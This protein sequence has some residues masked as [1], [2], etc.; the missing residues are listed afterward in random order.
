MKT[1]LFFII[2]SLLAAGHLQAQ[3]KCNTFSYSQ[4][5]QQQNP[6]LK[7]KLQSIEQFTQQYISQERTA[8]RGGANVITIPVV[9]H[10]LYH[11]PEENISEAIIMEQ[12]K[13]INDCFRRQNAD[14]TN[15]PARFKAVAAD[16]E[17]E[18]K[19]AISDP[20]R[21]STSG[22]VRKYTPIRS[23]V[24]DDKMKFSASMGADAWD[25]KSY[26]NIWVCN[27]ERMAG[28]ASLPG[29]DPAK[30]GVVLSFYAFGANYYG[31]GY[32]RGKT[33][34]HEIGHWLNLKHTWGDDMCG[35]DGVSDTPKQAFYSSGCPSGTP[36][37]CGNNPNGDMYMNYMDFTDDA[38]TNLFTIGQANRMRALF[39]PN[40]AR[41]SLLVSTGLQLPLI[42]ESP[43][44]D[45]SP[46]WLYAN[47][48]PN[49]TTSNLTIDLSYD[50]RWLS[51]TLIITNLNGQI[52]KQVKVASKI[53]PL[54]ISDLQPG[55]Y[56]IY[57][58][59][60]DGETLKQKFVKL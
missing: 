26:L 38:C 41:S 43:L 52:V 16:C 28:Y 58:K 32:D 51:T 47:L 7:E 8:A 3:R 59:K 54:V 9:F 39:A 23:W 29:S 18:F 6:L 22:I 60:S 30:D 24:D 57:G 15:T 56:I 10:I 45:E 36:V 33:A 53:Q 21:R 27:M 42:A 2:V 12:L 4:K 35:D 37:S 5:E 17:V 55:M 14:T 49:P 34:V 11:T 46:R 31:G 44:P 48:Y 25:A 40:G 50:P 20:R 1:R 19:L 13:I